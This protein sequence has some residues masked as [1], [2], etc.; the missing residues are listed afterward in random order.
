M[1]EDVMLGSEGNL[2]E[3]TPAHCR[4]LRLARPIITN[5]ELEIARET[6]TVIRS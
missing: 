5:E 2:L 4:R 6:E 1:A 3:E